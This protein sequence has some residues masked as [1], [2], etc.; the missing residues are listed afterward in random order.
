VYLS[1]GVRAMTG[2]TGRFYMGRSEN[3]SLNATTL[4]YNRVMQCECGVFAMNGQHAALD[5]PVWQDAQP[6]S[7]TWVYVTPS[8][9]V[10]TDVDPDS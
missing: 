9:G 2:D 10:W 5:G 7:G 3:A 1:G 8:G 6:G 4:R